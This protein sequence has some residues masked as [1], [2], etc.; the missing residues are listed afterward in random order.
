MR[1]TQTPRNSFPNKHWLYRL[2]VG[3]E[4]QVPKM[5]EVT[6]LGCALAAGVGVGLFKDEQ[7]LKKLHAEHKT[8]QVYDSEVRQSRTLPC[9]QPKANLCLSQVQISIDCAGLETT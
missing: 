6:A 3:K 5:A 7:A 1:V 9:D 2:N 8:Y 4:L